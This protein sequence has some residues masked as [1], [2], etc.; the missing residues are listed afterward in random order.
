MTYYVSHDQST[1][2]SDCNQAG[3]T[4]KYEAKIENILTHHNGTQ[5]NASKTHWCETGLSDVPSNQGNGEAKIKGA[6]PGLGEHNTDRVG[7]SEYFFVL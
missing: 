4:V 6:A 1:T 5:C 2:I 3:S 7:M